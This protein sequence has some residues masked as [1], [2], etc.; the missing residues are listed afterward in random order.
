MLDTPRKPVAWARVYFAMQRSHSKILRQGVWYPVVRDEL[1]D[2]LTLE[3]GGRMVDVPRKM[4]EIRPSRPTHF[5]VISR[6]DVTLE[7]LGRRYVV[8][9]ACSHRSALMGHPVKRECPEC[10]HKGEV[11]WWE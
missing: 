1:P 10:G 7:S 9:P 5:T 6:N 11:G 2:R 8:C 3:I 4:L